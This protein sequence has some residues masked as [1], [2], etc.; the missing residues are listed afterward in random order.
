MLTAMTSSR[1]KLL[2][3]PIAVAVLAGFAGAGI[4]GAMTFGGSSASPQAP[5]VNVHQAAATATA[6]P[7]T[8]VTKVVT[9]KVKP[10]TVQQAKTKVDAVQPQDTQP[11][12]PTTADSVVAQ[13]ITGPTRGDAPAPTFTLPPHDAG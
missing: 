8:T 4:Y 10:K 7:T 3:I 2:G 1:P 12:D 6:Q 11:T 5:T 9:V 13:P